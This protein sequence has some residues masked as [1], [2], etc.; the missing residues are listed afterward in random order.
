MATIKL[1]DK[2]LGSIAF[3]G[4]KLGDARKLDKAP[5]FRTQAFKNHGDKQI[6]YSPI[7]PPGGLPNDPNE[8]L[9]ANGVW[10]DNG[11]WD[12]TQTW[13]D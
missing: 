6:T 13:N 2:T 10:N 5:I 1:G 7:A 4:T 12:D 8:W 11:R 9:F 3:G